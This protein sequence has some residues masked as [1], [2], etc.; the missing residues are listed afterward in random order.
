MLLHQQHLYSIIHFSKN[1]DELHASIQLDATNDI[2]KGHFPSQ[3]VLPG[4]CMLQ[5]SQE[6]I[7]HALGE[8][9]LM[10]QTGQIKFLQMVDPTINNKITI[11]IKLK[12]I[13]M[14]AQV[15]WTDNAGGKILKYSA[16]FE[17]L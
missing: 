10:T 1:S 16:T 15:E 9:L 2:F 8:N 12:D 4:V 5:I 6:I 17:K 11:N 13:P 3:P 14:L 7:E